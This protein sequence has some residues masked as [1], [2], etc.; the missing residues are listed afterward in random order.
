MTIFRKE[1]IAPHLADL[2]TFYARLL[3]AVQG[4]PGLPSMAEQYHANTEQFATEFVDIDLVKI[5][6]AI[7][8]FKV[9]VDALKHLK[10][11]AS[12]PVHRP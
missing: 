4:V 12:V 11:L 3:S 2:E 10:R 7:G 5:E 8:H 6:K 9:E 1:H